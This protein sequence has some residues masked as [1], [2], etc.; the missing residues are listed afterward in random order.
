MPKEK[1]LKGDQSRSCSNGSMELYG[2]ER[3]D[4]GG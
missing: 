4:W 2:R 1:K 3:V